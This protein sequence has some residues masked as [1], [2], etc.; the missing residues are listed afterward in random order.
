MYQGLLWPGAQ[1]IG[2]LAGSGPEPWRPTRRAGGRNSCGKTPPY[3]IGTWIACLGSMKTS[4]QINTGEPH[5]QKRPLMSFETIISV[6]L[7]GWMAIG[8]ILM[9]LGIW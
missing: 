7:A 2:L 5:P 8:F 4:T 9:G 3:I 6:G 1:V